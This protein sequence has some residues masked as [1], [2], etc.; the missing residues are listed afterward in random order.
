MSGY[1]DSRL[2]II[3]GLR[4]RGFTP[5]MIK[6][7]SMEKHEPFVNTDFIVNVMRTELAKSVVRVFVILES[8][9]VNIMEPE[10]FT[11]CS[12]YSGFPTPNSQSTD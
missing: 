7:Y 3:K 12:P 4:R 10:L 2:L 9:E 11:E 8:L 1:Y 6:S 5:S